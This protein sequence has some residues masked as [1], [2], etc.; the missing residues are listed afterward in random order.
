MK[1]ICSFFWYSYIFSIKRHFFAYVSL[2]K[3]CSS[4]HNVSRYYTLY[5]VAE[6]HFSLFFCCYFSLTERKKI[7]IF[8]LY[9]LRTTSLVTHMKRNRLK[10]KHKNFFSL[11]YRLVTKNAIA[12]SAKNGGGRCWV[13]TY[14]Q[15]DAFVE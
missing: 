5:D 14:C 11:L 9:T 2:K 7:M 15:K 4:S 8:L 6:Q 12:K 10:C 3:I 1:T 13:T